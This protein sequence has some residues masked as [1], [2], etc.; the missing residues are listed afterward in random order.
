MKV[1]YTKY[2]DIIIYIILGDYRI[3]SNRGNRGCPNEWPMHVSNMTYKK[4]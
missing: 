1:I 4:H 3:Q 2:T